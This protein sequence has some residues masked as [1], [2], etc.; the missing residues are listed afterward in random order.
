MADI[1]SNI[2]EIDDYLRSILDQV[3]FTRPGKDQSLGR[4]IAGI[5]AEEINVRTAGNAQDIDGSPLKENEPRYAAR[6]L[7]KYG[8]DQPLI[9]TGQMLSMES[10]LGET[11]ISKRE[12]EM[13]YGTGQAPSSG[14]TGYLSA[15]DRKVTDREKAEYNSEDRPFY[16]LDE[17]IANE[18]AEYA[19]EWLDEQEFT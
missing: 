12:I 7:A 19:Q 9:R 16:G 3:D 11:T 17:R 4:D 18:V 2:D 15:G 14:G 6:K 1:T 8:T 13:R 10:L 5:V